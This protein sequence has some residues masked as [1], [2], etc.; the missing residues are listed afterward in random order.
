M[1][2][3]VRITKEGK[4]RPVRRRALAR[5]PEVDDQASLPS[6]GQPDRPDPSRDSLGLAGCR[7]GAA[8]RQAR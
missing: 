7:G 4:V 6:A 2:T 3:V 5:I 8:G 1:S